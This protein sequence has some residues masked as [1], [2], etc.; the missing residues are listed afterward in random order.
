M[1][2]TVVQLSHRTRA[3]R[4]V[5]GFVLWAA[6]LTLTPPAARA[7]E[8]VTADTVAQRVATAKSAQNH[9]ELAAYF[10]SQ[11]A[12]MAADVKRHEAM[13][14][15]YD[16]VWGVGKELMRNHCQTLIASDHKAQQAFEA[17]AQE[18]EKLAKELEHSH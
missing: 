17:L 15:S 6:L 13:L 18:H 3:P 7:G 11:A 16:W 5:A 10:R 8:P 2:Q 9:E 4:V 1:R 14:K 12:A